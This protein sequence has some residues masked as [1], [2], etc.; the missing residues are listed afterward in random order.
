MLKTELTFHCDLVTFMLITLSLL[1]LPRLKN[2]LPLKDDY[3][4]KPRSDALIIR[5]VTEMDAGNYTMV[6]T[7]KI[8]K[9]EQRRSFQLLVNGMCPLFSLLFYFFFSCLDSGD[10][11][12]SVFSY[13]S[14]SHHREGGGGGH[15]RVPVRQQSHPEVHRPWISH[16]C[17]HPVAMGV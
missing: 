8:T 16:A 9:E 13:S 5:G 15:R 6:L 7:N 11:S 4:V 10:D 17:A 3:R 12:P 2:G 1:C 14:P